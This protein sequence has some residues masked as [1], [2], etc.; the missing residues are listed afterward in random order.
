MSDERRK[1]IS[2]AMKKRIAKNPELFMGGRRG[3]TKQVIID[4]VKLQG[5]WEVEFYKWAKLSGL[6]PQKC[7]KGFPYEWNGIRT[8]FP[9][10]YL[11]SLDLYVEIKGYERER[12]IAKWSQ[13][14]EKLIV[15]K[16]QEIE[17]IKNGTFSGFTEGSV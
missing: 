16:K 11:P 14:P 6:D 2:E 4:G 8:Y 17:Q 1:K 12:D 5:N 7:A 13:F 15:L 9:D 3:R 10:F